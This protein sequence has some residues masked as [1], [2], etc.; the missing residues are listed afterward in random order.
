M[1]LLYQHYWLVVS[2]PLK[3][4]S[5]LGWLLPIYGKI[6]QSCSKPIELYRCYSP[7]LGSLDD[8]SIKVVYIPY[9][10]FILCLL[11]SQLRSRIA[12]NSR[13][14]PFRCDSRPRVDT[15]WRWRDV[16]IVELHRVTWPEFQAIT[17][18]KWV[19]TYGLMG[20]Y[21]GLMGIYMVGFHRNIWWFHGNIW[22]FHVVSWHFMVVSWDLM[23]DL[24][25]LNGI[26]LQNWWENHNAINGWINYKRPC[27]IAM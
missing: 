15:P 8:T 21:G 7:I 17:E 1:T 20:I 10:S 2:T 18:N 24:M 16:D 14:R 25:G 3:N 4:T 19:K 13:W 5:Q 9:R 6:I 11:R 12:W 27:S 26:Y 22:L 23:V